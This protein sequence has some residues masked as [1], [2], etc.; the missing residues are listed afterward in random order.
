MNGVWQRIEVAPLPCF[1]CGN[2]GLRCQSY[3][4][5]CEI[6]IGG[7]AG[8]HSCVSLPATPAA[9]TP[10]P[11]CSCFQNQGVPGGGKL[12]PRPSPGR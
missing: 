12:L 10:T 6:T 8:Q 5:Y 3:A 9:C 1:S 4:Q 11:T 2:A 7:A